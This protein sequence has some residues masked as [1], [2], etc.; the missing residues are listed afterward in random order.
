MQPDE[1][2]R[3]RLAHL[4]AERDKLEAATLDL[5]CCMSAAELHYA[6]EDL[7]AWDK[8]HGAEL[9]QLAESFDVDA[10]T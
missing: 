1:N 8:A 7:A 4:R 5:F 3:A 10:R 6:D 9:A 2:S